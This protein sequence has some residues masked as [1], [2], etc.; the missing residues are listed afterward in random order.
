MQENS[1]VHDEGLPVELFTYAEVQKSL[2][3]CSN[4]KSP[5]IDGVRY[6]DIKINW[7]EHGEDIAGLFNMILTNK[8][9]PISWN[10]IIQRNPKKNF[11]RNDLSTLRD[12]SLL[13]TS[14][15]DLGL[16]QHPRWSS[17]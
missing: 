16:L 9:F 17:L 8:K 4:G 11:N 5:G 10:A 2:S 14:K 1:V 6:E 7:E 13:P 15:A 3:S 12:I